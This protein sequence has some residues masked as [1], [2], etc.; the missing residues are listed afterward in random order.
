M[1]VVI[2]EGINTYTMD[3]SYSELESAIAYYKKERERHRVKSARN[4]LR[5]KANK[6]SESPIP[7]A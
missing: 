3:I 2:V 4:Y 7:P 1:A 6:S 5:R